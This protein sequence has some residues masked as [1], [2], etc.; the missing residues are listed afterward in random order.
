M[1][2]AEGEK[3]VGA[4]CS[5]ASTRKLI[6]P[7]Y[8]PHLAGLSRVACHSQPRERRYSAGLPWRALGCPKLQHPRQ[9]GFGRVGPPSTVSDHT[10]FE[11]GG[12][13]MK[14]RR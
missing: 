12:W 13:M 8:H 14:T 3:G 4:R 9:V 6:C 5:C 7:M 2:W 10:A 1:G 11:R